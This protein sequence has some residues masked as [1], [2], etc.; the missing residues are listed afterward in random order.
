MLGKL[1]K[2]LTGSDSLEGR[3]WIGGAFFAL[4]LGVYVGIMGLPAQKPACPI[5]LLAGVFM[6]VIFPILRWLERKFPDNTSL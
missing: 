4:L 5:M 6:L 1:S 3:V 2:R